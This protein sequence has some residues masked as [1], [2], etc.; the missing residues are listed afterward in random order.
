MVDEFRMCWR[1]FDELASIAG[2]VNP[3][4]NDFDG[5]EFTTA[6]G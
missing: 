2:C 4:P 3:L 5:A 6:D 1:F